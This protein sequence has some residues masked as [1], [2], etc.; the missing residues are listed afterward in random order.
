MVTDCLAI[1]H[2]DIAPVMDAGFNPFEINNI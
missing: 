2:V 1:Y